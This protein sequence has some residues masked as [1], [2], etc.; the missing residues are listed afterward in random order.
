MLAFFATFHSLVMRGV[1]RNCLAKHDTVILY[2][3]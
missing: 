3:N 1:A 2:A